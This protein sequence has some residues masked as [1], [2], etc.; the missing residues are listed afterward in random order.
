VLWARQ[1]HCNQVSS[2]FQK[3]VLPSLLFWRSSTITM[4]KHSSVVVYPS[5]LMG[6]MFHYKLFRSCFMKITKCRNIHTVLKQTL[7]II[8]HQMFQFLP[9][10]FQDSK[11]FKDT[12]QELKSYQFSLTEI[13]QSLVHSPSFRVM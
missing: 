7:K 10:W 13:A 2:Q 12:C 4:D 6:F 11:Y 3:H 9:K 8:C 1:L 5:N